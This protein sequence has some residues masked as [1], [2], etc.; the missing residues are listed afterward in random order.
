MS[1]VPQQAWIQNCTLKENIL[2]GKYLQESKYDKVV[3]ACALKPDFDILPAGDGTEIGEKVK[4]HV[5]YKGNKHWIP[6][7][8][9]LY[10]FTL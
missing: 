4:A 3:H 7:V 9:S 5:E 1:Y 2:F 10:H 8:F 6:V